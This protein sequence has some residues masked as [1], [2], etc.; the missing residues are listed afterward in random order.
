MFV[1]L[2]AILVL[3]LSL[4]GCGP[5]GPEM[6][7]VQGTVKSSGEPLSNGT[8]CFEDSAAGVTG[9][10]DIAAEGSYSINLPKGSYKVILLPSTEEKMTAEGMLDTVAVD[11][12]KFPRKYRV[13]ESSG[14]S[15]DVSA[16]ATL[17]VNIIAKQ[18]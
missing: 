1:R 17:A 4:N 14:I 12:K 9:S 16:N 13:S 10:S 8:I 5:Q 3:T 15:L 11:E 18:K 6:Y 7:V 2:I